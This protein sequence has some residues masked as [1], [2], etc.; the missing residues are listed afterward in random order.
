MT[1]DAMIVLDAVDLEAGRTVHGEVHEHHWRKEGKHHGCS[2]RSRQA[3][4]AGDLLVMLVEIEPDLPLNHR[5]GVC[6]GYV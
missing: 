5:I 4:V 2:R 6:L 1:N 3:F